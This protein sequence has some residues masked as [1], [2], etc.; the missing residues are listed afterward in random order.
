MIQTDKDHYGFEH[1]WA[2]LS[3]IKGLLN[4]VNAAR[5]CEE[6]M[7]GEQIFLAANNN[8]EKVLLGVSEFAKHVAFELYNLVAILNP[9]VIAIGGGIS[10]QPLL[11]DLIRQHMESINKSMGDF[12][13]LPTIV[14]CKFFND[15]NLIG[16][17]H[18]HLQSK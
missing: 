10:I 8:D 9:E 5:G 11:I 13:H 12:F 2:S 14:P 6:N 16:A 1:I 7:S 17:L 15:A 3:G 4:H 18:Q